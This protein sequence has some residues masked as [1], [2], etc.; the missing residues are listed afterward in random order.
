M[1]KKR[2]ISSVC[3]ERYILW[4]IHSAQVISGVRV[5]KT[6]HWF[7]FPYKKARMRMAGAGIHLSCYP[8]PRDQL[9]AFLIMFHS[10][11]SCPQYHVH[12]SQ[13]AD[14][15]VLSKPWRCLK[16]ICSSVS[17]HEV[18]KDWHITYSE[19]RW[20]RKLLHSVQAEKRHGAVKPTLTS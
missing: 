3:Q 13:T 15:Q 7:F 20:L 18:P 1:P 11:S 10:H 14:A 2:K 5:E 17:V 4:I 16:S 8:K 19:M 9:P 6:I 12:S